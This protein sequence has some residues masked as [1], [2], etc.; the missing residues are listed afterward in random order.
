MI[1]WHAMGSGGRVEGG[2]GRG[3]VILR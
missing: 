2:K 1:V 3:R